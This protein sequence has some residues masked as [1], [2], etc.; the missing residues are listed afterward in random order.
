MPTPTEVALAYLKT[1]DTTDAA[2][3]PQ[4]FAEGGTYTPSGEGPL[5]GQ[6]IADYAEAVFKSMPDSRMPVDYI[7]ADGDNVCAVWTYS[8]TMTGDYGPFPATNKSF[9]LQGCH[10]IKVEGDKIRSVI[11]RWDRLDMMMQLGLMG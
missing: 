2:G 11:S 5:S 1:W 9:S 10:V 7:F 8:A 6:A 3:M 4:H